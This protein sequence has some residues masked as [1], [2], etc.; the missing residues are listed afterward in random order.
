[1]LEPSKW[2]AQS[3]FWKIQHI[4]MYVVQ[5]THFSQY[6]PSSLIKFMSS[7]WD[8]A[9]FWLEPA[10]W[11]VWINRD[12]ITFINEKRSIG[13]VIRT[14][15]VGYLVLCKTFA[16]ADDH[17]RISKKSEFTLKTALV[18]QPVRTNFTLYPAYS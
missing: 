11:H 2:A 18:R 3:S 6:V 12:S 5:H 8:L 10:I 13:H 7:F 16:T 15:A 14:T 4:D 9:D 17:R 1:M